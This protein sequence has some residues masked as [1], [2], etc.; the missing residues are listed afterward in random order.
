M[1]KYLT[2]KINSD[3]NYNISEYNTPRSKRK[4]EIVESIVRQVA[5]STRQDR[6]AEMSNV[7]HSLP[8]FFGG[9]PMLKYSVAFLRRWIFRVERSTFKIDS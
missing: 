5:I 8:R 9:C 3:T 2:Q 7:Q 1:K 6:S 4:L